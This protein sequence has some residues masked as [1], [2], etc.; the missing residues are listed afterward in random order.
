[1]R[2][3]I[4]AVVAA[5]LALSALTVQDFNRRFQPPVRRCAYRPYCPEKQVEALCYEHRNWKR[6][7]R[8][9]RD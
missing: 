2:L 7:R 3:M 5:V 8:R 6:T 4:M 9:Q 1:M